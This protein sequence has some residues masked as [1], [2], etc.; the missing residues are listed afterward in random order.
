[1]AQEK[2]N[3]EQRIVLETEYIDI[4]KQELSLKLKQLKALELKHNKNIHE[5][6][7]IVELKKEVFKIKIEITS[8]ENFVN[9]LKLHVEQ[10]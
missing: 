9:S 8:K 1:M 2:I 6:I 3:F 5:E 10:S 4:L 7:K